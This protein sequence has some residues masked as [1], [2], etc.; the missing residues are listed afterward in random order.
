MITY[1]KKFL[2]NRIDSRVQARK[3][4]WDGQVREILPTLRLVGVTIQGSSK[5]IYA[6]YPENW[7]S[8][9]SW[10]KVG[11]AVRIAYVGGERRP[12]VVGH[13]L[14]VP[15][16]VAGGGSQFPTLPVGDDAILTGLQLIEIP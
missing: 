9:P 12:E 15:T 10:M 11:N 7:E 8:N 13:G 6:R 2:K 16:P 4:S 1:G 14:V 3:E 5:K